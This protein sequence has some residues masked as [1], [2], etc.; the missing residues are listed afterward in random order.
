LGLLEV[1]TELAAEKALRPVSGRALGEELAGYE[2]HMGVTTGADAAR[3]IAELE[4]D[5]TDGAISADG[6][7]MGTHCH[8]L[9]GSAGLRRALLAWIGAA[10]RGEN[11]ARAVD[12][13]LDE[14][15]AALERHVDIEGLLEL[16]REAPR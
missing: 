2:M 11:Y 10:S 5:E 15:A 3:P 1:E 6:R 16:A 8:G 12:A 7:T 9:F 13:A 4:G 14:I